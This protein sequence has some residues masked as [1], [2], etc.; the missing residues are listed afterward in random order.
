VRNSFKRGRSLSDANL[1]T[2][3]GGR[4]LVGLACFNRHTILSVEWLQV[5]RTKF[6]SME[7]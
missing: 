1:S 4:E 2:I 7:R 6:V 3:V 5:L